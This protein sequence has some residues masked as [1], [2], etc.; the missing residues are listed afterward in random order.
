MRHFRGTGDKHANGP[1]DQICQR[2][3]QLF[4]YKSSLNIYIM[5]NVK[6]FLNPEIIILMHCT[7]Q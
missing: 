7:Y 2:L 4:F 1:E 5:H 3:E 6:E